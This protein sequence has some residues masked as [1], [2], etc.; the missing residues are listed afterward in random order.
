VVVLAAYLGGPRTI[1]T[2][3]I[4]WYVLE[5]RRELDTHIGLLE[6]LLELGDE[7]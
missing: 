2:I 6:E 5:L 7:F 4:A 3:R 1:E